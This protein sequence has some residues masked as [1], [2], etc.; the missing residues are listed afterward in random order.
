[1]GSRGAENLCG[2]ET[3]NNWRDIM[4]IIHVFME[5]K[6]ENSLE[7]IQTANFPPETGTERSLREKSTH[8]ETLPP[9]PNVTGETG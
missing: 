5:K 1:M 7:E 8:W 3:Q 4:L 6:K 2:V 9:S